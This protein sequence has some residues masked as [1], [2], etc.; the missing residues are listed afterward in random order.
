M[1]DGRSKQLQRHQFGRR[2]E[3]LSED[4]LALA[5]EDLEQSKAVAEAEQAAKAGERK[6]PRTTPA[7]NRGALPKSLPRIEVVV[8]IADK[9]CPCC[10]GALHRI[11]EDQSEMLDFVPASLRVKVIRRPRYACRTCEQGVVQA[12]APERPIDGGMATEAL[13]AHVLISKYADH[14]PLYRQ[15]QILARHGIDLDRSTLCGWVGRACWW[16]RPLYDLLVRTVLSSNKLFADDTPLPVLD[17][18]RGRTKTGRLWC[19]ARDDRPWCGPAP[20]AVA[21]IY[22]EDRKAAHPRAHLAGFGGVLQTDGYSGFKSLLGARPPD[23]ITLAFCWAHARRKFYDV[24][25]SN[26]SLLAAEA[27]RRIAELYQI[28]AELRGRPAEFRRAKRQARSKPKVEAFHGWLEQQLA[29]ISGKS[30]LAEA[31]RYALRHWA[32]LCVFLDDGRVEIDDNVVERSIRPVALGR[33]NALFAGSD[34]GAE[35]WAIAMTL[36]ATAK[37]NEVEPFAWLRDGL[38]RVVS[39][40]CQQ[41]QLTTLLPWNWRP[42][43][44]GGAAA[45]AA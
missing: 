10:S 44:E 19:Y 17:P 18:G 31:M 20:P 12:P 35:H 2:S 38:E 15:A 37:L 41:H 34:G 21:Y 27:L 33:K 13:I 26:G 42:A 43:G 29:R 23:Q 22:S 40:Q 8:D 14:L 1:S 11:G 36:I 39:G 28:E 6:P 3:Q 45:V 32:G 7:R 25:V 5:M 24:H 4:Q 16:L 30:E 9:T